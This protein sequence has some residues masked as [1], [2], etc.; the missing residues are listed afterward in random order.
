MSIDDKALRRQVIEESL[1]GIWGDRYDHELTMSTAM[2]GDPY[3]PGYPSRVTGGDPAVVEVTNG[4]DKMIAFARRYT[5][6]TL[7]D[8]E[9]RWQTRADGITTRSR[10]INEIKLVI[11]SLRGPQEPGRHINM[12][13][14]EE[15]PH[16]AV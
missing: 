15:F 5:A 11:S 1:R 16:A 13:P 12:S 4:A 9:R 14:R 2:F 8:L 10:I 6:H 3:E 7:E